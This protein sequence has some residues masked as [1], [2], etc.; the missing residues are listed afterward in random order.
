MFPGGTK[1]AGYVKGRCTSCWREIAAPSS[2]RRSP[3]VMGAFQGSY[4]NVLMHDSSMLV[5]SVSGCTTQC[6]SE[7]KVEWVKG[8]EIDDSRKMIARRKLKTRTTCT[9]SHTLG[10]LSKDCLYLFGNV[11]FIL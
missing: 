2:F 3:A 11:Y 4:V 1:S 9:L 10:V 6:V 8:N 7:L 5:R